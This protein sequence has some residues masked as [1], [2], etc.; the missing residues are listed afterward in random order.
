VPLWRKTQEEMDRRVA[1]TSPQRLRAA[2]S[3]LA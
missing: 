1:K 2:L 3:A